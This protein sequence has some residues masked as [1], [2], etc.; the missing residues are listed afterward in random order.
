MKRYWVLATAM[1][2]RSYFKEMALG[3]FRCTS[4]RAEAARF[5]SRIEAV[6]SPA[7][8]HPMSM[9]EPLLVEAPR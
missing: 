4:K 1:P 5:A 9:F 7:Y 3:A 8:S 6:M 2:L